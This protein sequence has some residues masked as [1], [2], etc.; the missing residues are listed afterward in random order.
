MSPVL[1]DMSWP[2][3]ILKILLL[4]QAPLLRFSYLKNVSVKLK[5]AFSIYQSFL[6]LIGIVSDNFGHA[7]Y[8][9]HDNFWEEKSH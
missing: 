5:D 6:G 1:V 4:F 9:I 3:R 2:V 8:M 7:K